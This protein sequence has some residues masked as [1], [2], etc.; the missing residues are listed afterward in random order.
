MVTDSMVT[1]AY[2]AICAASHSS[3]NARDGSPAAR[4][5]AARSVNTKETALV[6]A[7]HGMVT[8]VCCTRIQLNCSASH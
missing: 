6:G 5:A 3:T 4:G 1:I 7:I 2:T 8:H